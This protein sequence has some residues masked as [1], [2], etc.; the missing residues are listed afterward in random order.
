MSAADLAAILPRALSQYKEGCNH[1]SLRVLLP[2][3]AHSSFE[4][5]L[6]SLTANASGRGWDARAAPWLN[7]TLS[8]LSRCVVLVLER[9]AESTDVLRHY[10]P[11]LAPHYDCAGPRANVNTFVRRGARISAA[12]AEVARRQNALDDLV[13]FVANELLTEQARVAAGVQTS[14]A[15]TS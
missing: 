15:V 5:K 14:G 9:C 13:Y 1:E 3:H 6:G 11:W 4:A 7:A 12:G 8:H 10:L 2:A